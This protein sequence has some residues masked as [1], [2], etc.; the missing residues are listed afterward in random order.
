MRRTKRPFP[1]ALVEAERAIETWRTACL[2]QLPDRPD[3][4]MYALL[5]AA[6]ARLAYLT[7]RLMPHAASALEMAVR[8]D[9][10]ALQ[11]AVSGLPQAR[12]PEPF[13]HHR[14]AGALPAEVLRAAGTALE[15]IARYAHVRD[16]FLAYGWGFYEVEVLGSGRLR[17]VDPPDWPGLRDFAQQQISQE[18]KLE[19]ALAARPEVPEA[20]EVALSGVIDV[21][22]ALSLGGLTARQFINAMT[23][24]MVAA[25]GLWMSGNIRVIERAD[26]VAEIGRQGALSQSEARRFVEL[27]TFDPGDNALT[28]FH[29]PVVGLTTSSL[30]ILPAALVFA[31]PN[32]IV[33]RLAVRRGPGLNPYANAIEADLLQRLVDHFAR[34]GVT[35]RTRHGYVFEALPGD[36][37]VVVYEAATRSLLLAEVKAFVLPDTVEEVVRANLAL[38]DALGQ[39]Q[40]IRRWAESLTPAALAVILGLPPG[41]IPERIV[42]AVI[43]NGFVGSDYL[44]I[45]PDV[46][47]ADAHYLLLPRFTGR[48]VFEAFGAHEARLARAMDTAREARYRVIRAG[49]VEVEIRAQEIVGQ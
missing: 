42:Y 1:E 39:I 31:N 49:P 21:P 28:L 3:V 47:V 12:P 27:L 17:F 6:S 18:V 36:I 26:L 44:P 8:E 7:H 41:T 32:A 11:F 37:D 30:A 13:V 43:A 45:P 5:A 2:A 34:E 23:K 9:L 33:P 48:S 25:A 24:L 29:C 15:Q 35:M 19:T 20:L 46:T 22:G 40:R 14:L 38:E 10:F 4:A 16:A